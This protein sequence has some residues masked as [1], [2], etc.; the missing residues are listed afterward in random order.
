[1][2]GGP[3]FERDRDFSRLSRKRFSLQ[4]E[5]DS[6]RGVVTCSGRVLYYSLAGLSGRLAGEPA[7]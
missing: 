3:K 4:A 5:F 6:E 7:P 2:I 1:M